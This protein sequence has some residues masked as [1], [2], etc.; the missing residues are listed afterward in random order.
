VVCCRT[1]FITVFLIVFGIEDPEGMPA[2]HRFRPPIRLNALKQFSGD[3]W[4]VVAV[5]AIFTLARFSEA[6]LVLRA[7]HV[8]FAIEWVPLVMI[9]KSLAY[10]FS[11]YPAGI[12]SDQVNRRNLLAAALCFSSWPIWSSLGL[13]LP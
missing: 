12:L 13:A 7:Q 5:G 1:A 11:A 4:R 2:R 10:S 6:F 9:V 3:Y 8:G